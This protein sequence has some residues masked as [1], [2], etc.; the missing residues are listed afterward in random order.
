MKTIWLLILLSMMACEPEEETTPS[1]EELC[2]ELDLPDCPEECPEDF[3]SVCGQSC[4]VEGE[5]CGNN[6]GDGRECLDG[7][8][9]CASHAPLSEDGCNLVCL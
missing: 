3:M 4:E 2:A 6:I 5:A 7:V 8:W 9:E 1:Q